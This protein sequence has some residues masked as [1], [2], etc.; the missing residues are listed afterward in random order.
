MARSPKPSQ[1]ASALHGKLILITGATQ[2]IGLALARALAAE[3]CNLILCARNRTRLTR[4]KAE[5]SA[6]GTRVITLSCD[7]SDEKSVTAA[8][9]TVRKQFSALDVLINCAGIAHAFHPV[10]EITSKEWNDV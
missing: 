8:F 5:F 9:K 1:P 7:V 2:G 3:R 10:A 4:L 6:S